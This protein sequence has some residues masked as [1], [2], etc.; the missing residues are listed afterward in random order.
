[1]LQ[2]V[3]EEAEQQLVGQT[4]STGKLLLRLQRFK[5]KKKNMTE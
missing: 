2:A 3:V 4:G 5:K 1:M